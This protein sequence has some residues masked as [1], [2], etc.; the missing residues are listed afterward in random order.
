MC[1]PFRP[2]RISVATGTNQAILPPWMKVNPSVGILHLVVPLLAQTPTMCAAFNV[3]HVFAA[4]TGWAKSTLLPTSLDSRVQIRP[5]CTRQAVFERSRGQIKP[6]CPRG[7][8][9]ILWSEVFALL[10]RCCPKPRRSA[11]PLRPPCICCRTRQN[12]LFCPRRWIHVCRFCLLPPSS[13][14]D[15]VPNCG[16]NCGK[17]PLCS[18][19]FAIRRVLCRC[20]ARCIAR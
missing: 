13:F 5:F 2:P 3:L 12:R 11:R 1:A 10:C 19:F 6:F 20:S 16:P 18:G 14:I 8:K 4:A 15:I 9:L 17:S 7:C